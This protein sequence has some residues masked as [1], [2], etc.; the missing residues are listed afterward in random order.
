MPRVPRVDVG[1]H[2]YHVLNRANARAQIFD[3]AKD[4]A[5][6]EQLL[7]DGV[8]EYNVQLLAYCLMPNHWH[9]VLIP[10]EDGSLSRF[11]GWL[12]NAH[13]RKW[14]VAKGTVGQGHL[15][16]GRYK[17][18]LCQ[19]D[20]HLF[21]IMRYV[22]RN[23]LKA[24]LVRRAENWQWSSVWRREKGTVNQKQLLSPWPISV[25]SDYLTILN[26]PQ[27]QEEEEVLERSVVKGVPYGSEEWTLSMVEKYELQQTMRSVGR[28]KNSG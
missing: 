3:D 5:L 12:C 9:L 21:T 8:E 23:A 24:N 20:E 11:M 14:H 28:P 10:Q 16:Q 26:T 19:E 1:G 18:F 6:F 22:E 17:S 13:T 7:T 15:Y 4:Y 2:V 27:T 25:P